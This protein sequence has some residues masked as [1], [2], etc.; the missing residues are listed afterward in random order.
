MLMINNGAYGASLVQMARC[1]NFEV[2]ELNY[3]ETQTPDLQEIERVLHD[4]TIS[5]VACLH[6]ETTTVILN[7]IQ[8]IGRLVKAAGKIWIVYAMSSFC[9]FTHLRAH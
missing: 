9:L 5:H 4:K 8:D 1:L 3:L 7:P 6:C 2:V